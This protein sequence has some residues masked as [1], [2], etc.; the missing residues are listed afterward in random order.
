VTGPRL[1]GLLLGL[2][3]MASCSDPFGSVE[4]GELIEARARWDAASLSRYRMEVRVGCF[5]CPASLPVFTRIE[6]RGDSVVSAEQLDS[7]PY[8]VDIPL[9]AWPTVVDAFDVIA[10]AAGSDHYE[11]IEAE[12]DPSLGYPRRIRLG[13]GSG[14]TDCG[15]V[16]EF[17]NLEPV[18]P[19]S[20]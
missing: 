20:P 15:A 3:V 10:G 5:F 8:P 18:D 9:D 16:F 11:T 14:V 7:V 1:V 13:C 6:I 17:R 12:Y 19:H 4:Q 2:G